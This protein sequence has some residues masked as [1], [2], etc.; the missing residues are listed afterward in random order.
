MYK[1]DDDE[2]SQELS[3]ELIMAR[4]KEL[5][6]IEED[7]E[8]ILEAHCHI[9]SLVCAQGEVI[10]SIEENISSS[11][12]TSEKA[13]EELSE[14]LDKKNHSRFR[15]LIAGLSTSAAAIIIAT[16]AIKRH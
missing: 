10:D 13:E 1:S 4:N 9:H 2:L 14:A 15:W 11:V 3:Q 6:K 16:L 5:K 7:T 12:D 8:N